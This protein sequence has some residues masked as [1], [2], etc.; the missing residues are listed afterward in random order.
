M[1]RTR[2]IMPKENPVIAEVRRWRAQVFKDAGG[3]LEGLASLLEERTLLNQPLPGPRPVQ[4]LR[5]RERSNRA[6]RR[7]EQ[8]RPLLVHKCYGR[9]PFT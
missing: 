7:R 8:G 6:A 4:S 1:K 2:R 5:K 9:M 3:T